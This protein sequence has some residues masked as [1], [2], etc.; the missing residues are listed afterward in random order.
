MFTLILVYIA[1]VTFISN[2]ERDD[3]N[4]SNKTKQRDDAIKSHNEREE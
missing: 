3:M 2:Y 1:Y 4:P